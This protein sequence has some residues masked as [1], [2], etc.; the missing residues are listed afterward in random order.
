MKQLKKKSNEYLKVYHHLNNSYLITGEMIIYRRDIINIT[1]I[2]L[3][4]I[5][6]FFV[7]CLKIEHE[8]IIDQIVTSNSNKYLY[9]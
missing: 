4:R 5:D 7:I 1:K 2:K 6:F 8:L 3:I 9:K